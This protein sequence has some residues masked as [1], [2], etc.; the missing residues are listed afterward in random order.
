MR[1]AV[2]G[3]LAAGLGVL[4]LA[5][6]SAQPSDLAEAH[7]AFYGA[8][9]QESAAMTEAPCAAGEI[10]ACELRSS[11]LHFELK[12]AIGEPK[13]KGKAFKACETCPALLEAFLADTSRGQSLARDVL[14]ENEDDLDAL[15]FLGK[16]D[17]NYVWLQAG[18]LGRKTGWNEYREARRSLD[19]VLKHHPGH[20]RAKVA[21][22]WIDY[23]VDTRVPWA[24][25]WMLG[26]GS[27]ER[28]FVALREA[29]VADAE[30][31]A[32]AEAR[33][34]LWDMLVREKMYAEAVD[35]A[36]ELQREF[37]ANTDLPKFLQAHDPEYVPPS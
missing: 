3:I 23:I 15:F 20:V 14:R 24:V 8:R 31:Y 17:L 28:A 9:F 5:P 13:D 4:A 25:R 22:G 26:G 32:R 19:A 18:T 29:S 12:R 37:P 7:A 35:L 34:G 33:F 2:S 36:R 1:T 10:E 6:L 27:K 11:A 21:R 16:L 30:V